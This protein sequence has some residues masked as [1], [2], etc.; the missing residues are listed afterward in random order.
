MQPFANKRKKKRFDYLYFY[1]FNI[2]DM[3]FNIGDMVAFINESSKGKVIAMLGKNKLLVMLDD[4]IE[5]PVLINE[6]IKVTA[7]KIPPI[8]LRKESDKPQSLKKTKK[9]VPESS[10]IEKHRRPDGMVEVDLHAEELFADH[11]GMSNGEILNY[12]I[13]YFLRCLDQ[14]ELQRLSKI[15][16]IHGIGN[17]VLKSELRRKLQSMGYE[18]YDAS[19][20]RYGFG[21]TAV[22]IK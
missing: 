3:P 17:G 6:L 2:I 20:S 5:I 14:A 18:F 7:Y 16:F 22:V 11:R 21:A 9:I 10:L 19:L 8:P 1:C 13:S 12:Q 4:G 15:I